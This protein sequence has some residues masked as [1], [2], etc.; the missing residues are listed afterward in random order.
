MVEATMRVKKNLTKEKQERDSH[1]SK[2][3]IQT[4]GGMSDR[5]NMRD[6][7][8]FVPGVSSKGNFKPRSSRH[9]TFRGNSGGAMR[10]QIQRRTGYPTE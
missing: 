10:N 4:M 9:S 6:E 3:V 8:R 1:R 2:C 5:S 7:R